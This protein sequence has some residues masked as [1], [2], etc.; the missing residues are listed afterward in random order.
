[1]RHPLGQYQAFVE[2]RISELLPAFL[3]RRRDEVESLRHALEAGDFNRLGQL[4][5]RMRGVGGSYG[6]DHVT[7]LGQRIEQSARERDG[8]LILELIADY[9]DYLANVRIEFA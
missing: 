1:V 6:F 3:M 2:K 9:A 4:G 8:T 7:T 5:H